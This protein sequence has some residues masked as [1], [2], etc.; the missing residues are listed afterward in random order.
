MISTIKEILSCCLDLLNQ[1]NPMTG[2][3]FFS[4]VLVGFLFSGITYRE[5]VDTRI[6]PNQGIKRS[7]KNSFLFVVMFILIGIIVFIMVIIITWML[8]PLSNDNSDRMNNIPSNDNDDIIKIIMN[9]IE[10][11]IM[12]F[13]TTFVI[14]SSIAV[15]GLCC[16]G[17]ISYIQ[18]F[19]L[20]FILFS[21]NHL[22]WNLLRFFDYSTERILMQKIGGRYIFIHRL[23]LEYF[24]SIRNNEK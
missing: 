8:L 12:L 1:N 19:V 5:A 13:L 14:F 11:D 4:W 17:G 23:L 3:Y 24:S 10:S 2:I 16:F 9:E 22:P 7:I 15:V 6:V 20:R 21:Q 18:H